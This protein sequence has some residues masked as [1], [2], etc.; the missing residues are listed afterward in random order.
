[1][2]HIHQREV[3][4][5]EVE[6][7]ALENYDEPFGHLYS[8]VKELCYEVSFLKQLKY[9]TAKTVG[10]LEA[11]LN[12]AHTMLR[13]AKSMISSHEELCGC[14]EQEECIKRI[15]KVLEQATCLKTSK[16]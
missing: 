8:L 3:D 11:E 2:T 14:V 16:N 5:K 1:M 7:I 9:D 10:Y 13:E 12:K 6:K 15:D 4:L